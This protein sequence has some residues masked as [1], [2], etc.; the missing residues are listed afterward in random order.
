MLIPTT[1]PNRLLPI[2]SESL[3]SWKVQAP[4][5]SLSPLPTNLPSFHPPENLYSWLTS[6]PLTLLSSYVNKNVCHAHNALASQVL[7]TSLKDPS[8]TLFQWLKSMG[9]STPWLGQQKPLPRDK[10]LNSHIPHSNTSPHPSH[11]WILLFLLLK[12]FH[13]H[14]TF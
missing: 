9:N 7:T 13:A 8:S 10:V 1:T 14:W 4:I 2:L 5:P 11:S 6:L 12:I 3:C